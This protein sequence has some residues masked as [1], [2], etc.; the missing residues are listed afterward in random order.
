MSNLTPLQVAVIRQ[1]GYEANDISTNALLK[2]YND[3]DL[4]TEL[5]DIANHGASGGFSGFTYYTETIQFFDDNAALI[6]DFAQEQAEE[7]GDDISL[8]M[9]ENFNCMNGLKAHEIAD[10]IFKKGS[11]FEATVKNCLAWYAL[12]ETARVM[13]D[14]QNAKMQ[15]DVDFYGSSVINVYAH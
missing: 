1:L 10:G 12:E 13:G 4:F 5:S 14:D 15:I 11:D 8:I 6:L 2:K 7:M 3:E 9:F